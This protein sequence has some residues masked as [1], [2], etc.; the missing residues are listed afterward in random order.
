[1]SLFEYLKSEEP[2]DILNEDY[3]NQ[4]ENRRPLA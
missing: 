2:T 1:M 3:D 4:K